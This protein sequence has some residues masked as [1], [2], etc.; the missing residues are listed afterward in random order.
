MSLTGSNLLEWAFAHQ[1]SKRGD[2]PMRTT[3]TSEDIN[4]DRR[5][6]TA[7]MF[8]AAAG[9]TMVIVLVGLGS[10]A[11]SAPDKYTLQFPG[12]LAFSDFRGYEDWQV[13]SVSQT[14]DLLKVMVANPVMIEAYKAGV[15]GNGQPFPDGSKIAKLEWKPKKMTEAPFQ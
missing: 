11:M 15:P 12:G 10:R 1:S 13:V 6:S 2:L 3:A 5:R 7:A 8:V 14:D 9:A 4:R